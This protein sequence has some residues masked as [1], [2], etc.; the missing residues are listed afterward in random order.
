MGSS[1]CLSPN[2]F[3]SFLTL[4]NICYSWS[5][6]YTF[7]SSLYLYQKINKKKTHRPRWPC[8]FSPLYFLTI[9]VWSLKVICVDSTWSDSGIPMW[10][11]YVLEIIFE[12]IRLQIFLKLLVTVH[13]TKYF[14]GFIFPQY[15]PTC[16]QKC[17]FEKKG[18]KMGKWKMY[19]YSQNNGFKP[20]LFPLSFSVPLSSLPSS[21]PFPVCKCLCLYLRVCLHRCILVCIT[22]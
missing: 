22:L 14:S 5:H 3:L 19:F 1:F 11:Q 17:S 21:L 2:A 13:G 16:L 7:L 4:L 18:N 8:N 6:L 12:G 10:L 15:S 20:H 9:P